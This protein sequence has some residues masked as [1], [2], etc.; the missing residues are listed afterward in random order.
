[1]PRV[2]CVL[3]ARARLGEGA[4]WSVAMQRLLW[5]D[6]PAGHL[7]RFD[8]ATGRN[9]TWPL[10][11]P[12][13]CVAETARG[14]VMAAL[15]DGFVEIDLRTGAQAPPRGP[16]PEAFGHRYNDGTVDPEGRFLAGT[17]PRDGPSDR[18]DTGALV[19][20]DG[21]RAE[22]LERGYRTV[23]GMAF[24]PDGRTFYISDSHPKVRMVWSRDYHPET[25]R[26]GPA[27]P[28][29][30]T[31]QVA[32]RPDGAAMDADG[33][34]WMAGVGGWQLYRIAPDG[35]LDMTVDLPVER[36]TRIAFGGADLKT[37]FVTSIRVEDDSKQPRSGGLFALEIKG[38][39]GLPMPVLR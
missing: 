31:R 14:T 23:N 10:G 15:T 30:D 27:R 12:V 11:R 17:M 2:S 33:C 29:F 5:V 35:R 26:M 24:A 1:M 13:G 37:L 7:H 3:D 39:Q 28:F 34:Y 8:P 25:G 22:V 20:L 21:P 38:V 9:E 4:V 18:D 6:I 36:P 16:A 19:R 32:G